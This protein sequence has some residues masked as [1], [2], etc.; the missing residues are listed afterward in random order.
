MQSLL[1]AA[2][3][4]ACSPPGFAWNTRT[5]STELWQQ[6]LQFV[7]SLSTATASR[8]SPQTRSE[9]PIVSVQRSSHP[10][11]ASSTSTRR[12]SKAYKYSPT[13]F[14]CASRWPM[15]KCWKIGSSICMAV[16][17]CLTIRMR[18]ISSATCLLGPSE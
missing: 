4:V 10:L 7:N 17:P 8:L 5:L 2:A 11:G 9:R 16:R 13:C 12:P 1:L 3:T 15:F 6:A 18:R 14:T